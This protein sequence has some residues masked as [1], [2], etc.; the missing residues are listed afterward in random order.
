MP[1]PTPTE[2]LTPAHRR[3][4]LL[5]GVSLLSAVIG[6]YLPGWTPPPL[7]DEVLAQIA[8]THATVKRVEAGQVQVMRA[9]GV[10]PQ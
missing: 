7:P 3:W 6:R 1:D 10:P 8:D 4:L 9:A 2:W 5:L